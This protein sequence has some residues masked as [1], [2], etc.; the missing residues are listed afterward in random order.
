MPITL[1]QDPSISLI[2]SRILIPAVVYGIIFGIQ[3]YSFSSVVNFFTASVFSTLPV[4]LLALIFHLSKNIPLE[5]ESLWIYASLGAAVAVS[6][7]SY[8]MKK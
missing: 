2:L 3:A 5:Y 7:K 1:G 8:A 4:S 6:L